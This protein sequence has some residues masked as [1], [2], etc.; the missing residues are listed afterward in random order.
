[1]KPKELEE[2]ILDFREELV[3][4]ALAKKEWSYLDLIQMERVK[5]G[6]FEFA[7]FDAILSNKEGQVWQAWIIHSE[8]GML[9]VCNR[10]SYA[11]IE[12]AICY[13]I[14]MLWFE[15]KIDIVLPSNEARARI[16]D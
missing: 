11:T 4:G 6:P 16:Q 7:C 5:V 10:T 14:G 2:Q 3:K 8:D 15:D 12:N 1:M 9:N 13:H